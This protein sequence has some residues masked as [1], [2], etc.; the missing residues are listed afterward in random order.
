MLKKYLAAAL[1]FVC[2]CCWTF[3][4]GSAEVE[5]TKN[6]ETGAVTV[7]GSVGE[8]HANRMLMMYCLPAGVSL[9]DIQPESGTQASTDQIAAIAYGVSGSDGS[10][11]FPDIKVAGESGNYRFYITVTNS[12]TVYTS[13]TVH[14]ATEESIAEF[15]QNFSNKGAD[16][17]YA[18]LQEETGAGGLGLEIPLYN[19]LSEEGK[20]YA[21]EKLANRSYSDIAGITDSIN[22]A[23]A[24]AGIEKAAD[25][26]NLDKLLYPTEYVDMAPYV[27][28][29]NQY[30]HM[31][32]YEG[33]TTFIVLG[34]L[35]TADRT[36]ILDAAVQL[37]FSSSDELFENI[38]ISVINF[39]FRNCDGYGDIT[40]IIE[41]HHADVL[42]DLDLS[43]YQNSQYRNDLN[44]E[45]LNRSFDS[46]EEL[47]AA[48]EAYL[49]N[50]DRPI[51]GGSTWNGTGS[52]EV[53]P[54]IT[55]IPESGSD[56][57]TD[58]DGYA[59]A[60][61]AI[62]Y[63]A[64]RDIISGRGDGRF[65]P[66]AYVTREEFV[67]MVIKAFSLY[68]ENAVCSF[69]DVP[70]GAWYAQYIAS[71][72]EAGVVS[73]VT[74]T[75]FGA[76]SNITR[77]DIAVIAARAKGA[78]GTYTDT[79][80]T[81]N[82]Q[83]ADYAKN[84]VGWMREMGCISGYEDGTFRP[85][86][87]CTR[88]EAA[89]I[90][91]E[92][93]NLGS[94]ASSE[95]VTET[96]SS[97]D[98]N[99]AYYIEARQV[100]EALGI[101][102]TTG[103]GAMT[104]AKISRMELLKAVVRALNKGN[105]PS[106][107]G[108]DS[109]YTDVATSDL[110]YIEEAVERGLL[111]R[112]GSA[113]FAP[114]QD[115]DYTFA[116]E[117]L[118]KAAGYD[119]G[120]VGNASVRSTLTNRLRPG[121]AA[122][123]SKGDAY[124]ML[125]NLIC[126]VNVNF[127]T[128]VHV[129]T[130]QNTILAGVFGITSDRAKLIGNSDTS[131][132]WEVCPEGQVK[133]SRQANGDTAVFDYEGDT[134]EFLGRSVRV[135]YDTE[136]TIIYMCALYTDDIIVEFD[137]T[138]F[139]EYNPETRK[140][141]WGEYSA[142]SRWESNMRI[143]ERQIPADTD[144]IYNGSYT[145]NHSYVYGLLEDPQ[146]LSI[147]NVEL[148]DSDRNG[149][150]DLVKVEAYRPVVVWSVNASEMRIRDKITNQTVDLS[151][152]ASDAQVEI[153]DKDGK[154]VRLTNVKENDVLSIYENL[155]EPSDVKIIT[156][157]Q[158][159]Q[160]MVSSIGE[161]DRYRYVMI[162]GVEYP[163]SNA[164]AQYRGDIAIGNE[165]TLYLDHLGFV[166][167]TN[168]TAATVQIANVVRAVNVENSEGQIEVKLFNLNGEFVTA[169]SSDKLRINGARVQA[170]DDGRAF[171]VDEELGAAVDAVDK[172]EYEMVQY[173]LDS[174]G[175]IREINTPK[176]NPKKGEF[177]YA[178][179]MNNPDTTW[180]A[181][182]QALLCYKSNGSYFIPYYGANEAMNF[183][184][185]D[186]ETQTMTVPSKNI[187]TGREEF[188]SAEQ[189]TFSNDETAAIIAYTFGGEDSIYADLLVIVSDAASSPKDSKMYIVRDIQGAVNSEDEAGYQINC[190]AQD[191]AEESFITNGMSFPEFD[192]NSNTLTGDELEV[193]VGDIIKVGLD[194]HDNC[195][196]IA[197]VYDYSSGQLTE[198]NTNNWYSSERM[199]YGSVYS[200]D[201]NLFT[202]VHGQQISGDVD[203]QL[204]IGASRA[205]T[206][207]VIIVD[208]NADRVQERVK[209]GTVADLVGYTQSK[210]NYS[211]VI[212]YSR[213]GEPSAVFEY[214]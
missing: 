111:P 35:G 95:T 127:L 152:N 97:G 168:M 65:E 38:H 191:G 159:T 7:T 14:I 88:A 10:Y 203:G 1:V 51:Q 47:I 139:L 167:E 164:Y 135:Y 77:Q 63:L 153:V 83:I 165:Y 175:K 211:K 198:T 123:L 172:I 121:A 49:E 151:S 186:G 162:E 184:G 52:P 138:Q 29:V 53:V 42:S 16:E 143:R 24:E 102:E 76:G 134:T 104:D 182:N 214:K 61:E 26:A 131:A 187:T 166:C 39:E 30:N 169:T 190:V 69:T 105:T 50:P 183:V 20:R 195:S 119:P 2:V 101:L 57:F 154:S 74:D 80:F 141:S 185:I 149:R 81:D 18:I 43:S 27:D 64:A 200:T 148:I 142:S 116:M 100:M 44:K 160:G 176:Q 163:L 59:W 8:E 6:W 71:G 55:T 91:Y 133:L 103:S 140:I 137:G 196:A 67:T 145:E 41:T 73:G 40:G 23:S 19:M 178:K 147:G 113:G 25:G 208:P 146:T 58:L 17:I 92:V 22:E 193:S 32:E 112:N 68:S 129:S 115:A 89:K 45:L 46:I 93:L 78:E 106:Y 84:S 125:F 180:T 204:Q 28:M 54:P 108:A 197:M 207:T 36:E 157:T 201:G 94:A 86:N 179:G 124:V 110:G 118:I 171:Y 132:D 56:I 114:D 189:K 212:I 194:T 126:D 62:G 70:A 128:S 12:D 96:D 210:T 90:I 48:I 15:V 213:Y 206:Q 192:L 156:T 60:D 155:D 122:S 87:A 144:M 82:A 34:S 99:E 177:G 109:S 98:F 181:P 202:Y 85:M 13:D 161:T 188:Y 5:V 33:L 209:V 75:L 136:N 117:L 158:T 37:G 120:G 205:T 79:G 4:C 31:E 199:V 107:S 174:E 11:S 130:S 150:I 21:V 72:V 9:E 3:V 170:G 66:A 173:R